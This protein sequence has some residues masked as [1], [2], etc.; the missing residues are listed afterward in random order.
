MPTR[1]P[2]AVYFLLFFLVSTLSS[3]VAAQDDWSVQQ[4]PQLPDSE[5]P[6]RLFDG[7][8]LTGWDGQTEKYWSVEDGVIVGRNTKENA[9]KASTYLV[10]KKKYRNFR[11][12][13]EAKLVT[14]E[15]HSGI[16]LWGETVEK[17]NDPFSYRGH[18]VMFPSNY[19]FYDLY[20]RNSIYRDNGTAKKA[21][22]QHDWNR[23]EILAIGNRIRH[24]INGKLV[25]DWTDPKPELC[26][27]GPI[28]LQ[29][30]SNK[31]PQEVHFRGLV[32]T[33]NP[34]NELV[35]V[36]EKETAKTDSATM[37]ADKLADLPKRLQKFVDDGTFSGVVTLVAKN[38]KVAQLSA[39]GQADLETERPMTTGT[40]FAIASMTK[41]ITATALMILV[42]EDKVSLDDAVSQY[43]PEFANA[44]LKGDEEL[45]REITIRDVLTHTSGLG[46]SQ[47]VKGSLEA[48]AKELAARPFGF[49][50]GTKW[51]YSPGLNVVGRIIEVASGKSYAEFLQDRIFRPLGML[52]TTFEPSETQKKRLAQLY[53]PGESDSGLVPHKHWIN[54]LSES[55]PPNPS[56]GLF[57]TASDMA[58][59]Y[60]MILN[61][62]KLDGVRIV[63]ED[64]VKQMK[65]VQ[66]GELQT[67]FTPGNGW[68]LGWCIVRQ[69][70]AVTASLSSGT[71]GH[72]GA[73]GTQGW[74]DPQRNMIFVLMVQR[75]K[76]PNSDASELRKTFHDL[77]VDAIES[78]SR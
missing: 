67:G 4:I 35:T 26:G 69:P 36:A 12:I 45:S 78:T 21:G 24:V 66:T 49:Q 57:S 43:I 25:A 65:T 6:V 1:C 27:T 47:E 10:T 76:L 59:F 30:H 11:L 63:S 5:S 15:M 19:G 41:P 58:K 53:A 77:A 2:R 18:L 13:F 20:R 7:K 42:D 22:K 74:I 8:T 61:G 37:N 16:A 3:G 55:R 34:Q 68:G 70:Q 31:V 50:P 28:G 62:G 60:Q 9:P 46:G 64:A 75:A 40:M 33:E 54:D 17:Q 38:G 23:M 72:G 56:G 73:F 32:L 52:D 51:Q 39:I 71:F 29:L 14:S 48:T 44:K